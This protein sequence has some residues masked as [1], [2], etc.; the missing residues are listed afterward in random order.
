MDK[1]FS[2][3]ENI[4]ELKDYKCK[5]FIPLNKYSNPWNNN[6]RAMLWGTK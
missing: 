2:F 5:N 1:E 4:H 6:Q 3:S